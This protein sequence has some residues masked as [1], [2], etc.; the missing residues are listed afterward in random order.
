MA[1]NEAKTDDVGIKPDSLKAALKSKGHKLES[2]LWKPENPGDWMCGRLT[3]ISSDVGDYNSDMLRFVDPQG[4]EIAAWRK[5]T[6]KTQINDSQIGTVLMIEYVGETE[7]RVKGQS[8]MKTFDVFNL[9]A[10]FPTEL[11]RADD[12]PF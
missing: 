11:T 2:R 5:G 12:L 3:Q 9:G 7:S 10:D 1:K 8:A 4:N 6:L